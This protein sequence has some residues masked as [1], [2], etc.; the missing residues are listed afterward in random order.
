MT[1]CLNTAIPFLG[2]DLRDANL[3]KDHAQGC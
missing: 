2:L 3:Y 1:T